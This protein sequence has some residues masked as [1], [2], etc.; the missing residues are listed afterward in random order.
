MDN[1]M[2][3]IIKQ[4]KT[5][6]N[7]S[8]KLFSKAQRFI[9]GG[10]NS[11]VRAFRGVGGTPLFIRSAKGAYVTD[12]DGK[13]YIDYVGSWGP[14]I[15]G[16][17][18]P[19]VLKAV[20]KALKNGL[21]FGAP[22]EL[23]VKL[24]AKVCQLL[25]SMELVRCVNSGTETVMS[26]I[27]LARGYTCR[28]KIIKFSGCYHGHTD[29]MLVAAGSGGLTFGIPN[30]AGVPESVAQH[31]LVAE[32]NR[33]ETVQALFEKFG[34]DI[35]AVIVEP[36]A[37]NMNCVLPMA[38]FLPGLR[39]LCDTYGSVLIFDE[40]ITGFRVA[41]GGAQAYYNVKPDITVLGKIIGGG[42]PAGAFGG[43]RDIMECIAPLGPVYQA[44]TLSGNPI[45]MAAG[46]ATLALVAEPGFY[47]RLEA[48][49][50]MLI[51]G[52]RE[53]AQRFGL[54][55]LATQVGGIFGLYFTQLEKIETDADVKKSEVALFKRFFHG[56]LSEGVYLA[57]S[58]FESGFISSA[59]GDEEI[60]KTL[61]AAETVFGELVTEG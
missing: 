8:E 53:R 59:H 17:T 4:D 32:Y 42:F 27:R 61:Q 14:M 22:T 18:H 41:L 52:L 50:Q 40:V 57:P 1:F 12:V 55:F 48:K 28:Q 33:L 25:P 47:P 45:A 46:L 26:A 2:A 23:E 13:S 37:G 11:P 7:H 20:K 5:S 54:P 43:K 35:A 36:V 44:G 39:K 9:P 30:S 56:M 16:H 3:V 24:A 15:A 51:D 58:A 34:D 6:M 60:N 10:V 49:L 21:S 31:T 29:A 38:G 19:A